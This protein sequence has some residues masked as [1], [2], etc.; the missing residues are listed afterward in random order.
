MTI[1]QYLSDVATLST[2]TGVT[3]V[4]AAIVYGHDR[5]LDLYYELRGVLDAV[6]QT[7]RD[8]SIPEWRK[9]R[10]S[11]TSEIGAD[12]P[13]Y[14]MMPATVLEDWIRIWIDSST[15]V[16]DSQES[17]EA[18]KPTGIVAEYKDQLKEEPS[19]ER[20]ISG[21]MLVG[22]S[23]IGLAAFGIVVAVVSGGVSRKEREQWSS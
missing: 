17:I 3:S 23:A 8:A 6:V 20:R 14:V 21:P 11:M 22:I 18:G 15:L 1:V 7:A 16:Q 13:I 12:M 2:G 4:G 10:S 19:P 9:L 5:L